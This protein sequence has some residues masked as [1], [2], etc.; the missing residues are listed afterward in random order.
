MQ[1]KKHL[2]LLG[3][4]VRDKVTGIT[5]VVAHVG[6]DLYG[7]V[8]AVVNPGVDKDGKLKDTVWLDV[9]RLEILDS[10]PVMEVPNFDFG[11]V[12]EGRQGASEKP[13]TFHSF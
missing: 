7:C 4:K 1:V 9:S 3:L 5:G 6:F 12:A 8:Q 13:P 10:N 2:S 11:T